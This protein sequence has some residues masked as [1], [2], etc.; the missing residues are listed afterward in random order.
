MPGV[1]RFVLRE[2]FLRYRALVVESAPSQYLNTSL[3]EKCNE[4]VFDLLDVNVAD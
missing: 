3:K 2:K 1:G 4:E